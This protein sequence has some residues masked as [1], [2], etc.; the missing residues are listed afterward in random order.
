MKYTKPQI[1]VQGNLALIQAGM[2]NCVVFLDFF[3]LATTTA[4]EADE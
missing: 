2:K 3:L 4:Y 1:V